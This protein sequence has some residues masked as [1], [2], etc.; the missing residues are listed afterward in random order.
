MVKE[1]KKTFIIDIKIQLL[2]CPT[3]RKLD[4]IPAINPKQIT[5]IMKAGWINDGTKSITNTSVIKPT[6]T[7]TIGPKINPV[8]FTI[9][10][11][12]A[13][14]IGGKTVIGAVNEITIVTLTLTAVNIVI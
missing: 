12:K 8:I 2:P 4:P 6:I 13:I 1:I 9:T 14:L 10:P 11:S 3:L 5:E 7:P